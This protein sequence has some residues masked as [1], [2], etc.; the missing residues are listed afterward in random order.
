MSLEIVLNFVQN[1]R[2]IR[3]LYLLTVCLTAL[4]FLLSLFRTTIQFS[5]LLFLLKFSYRLLVSCIWDPSSPCVRFSSCKFP[6]VTLMV[7]Y[8]TF[9]PLFELTR[10]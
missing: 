9:V 7:M 10:E 1:L 5:S 4:Q 3:D 2:L 6:L 8:I